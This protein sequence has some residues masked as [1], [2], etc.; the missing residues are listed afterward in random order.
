M[1]STDTTRHVDRPMSPWHAA[2]RRSTE[3]EDMYFRRIT[4]E[5]QQDASHPAWD[6]PDNPYDFEQEARS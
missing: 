1:T 6:W 3:V 5:M 2:M 4:R